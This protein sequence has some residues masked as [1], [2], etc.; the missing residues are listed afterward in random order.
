MRAKASSTRSSTTNDSCVAFPALTCL[1]ATWNPDMAAL[2]GT[3]IGEVLV[4]VVIVCSHYRPRP[5]FLHS[6]FKRRQVNLV[7]SAVVDHG[8]GGVAVSPTM[9]PAASVPRA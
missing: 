9:P 6:R 8:I 5:A 4:L 1:A 7:E 3:S 2:Y